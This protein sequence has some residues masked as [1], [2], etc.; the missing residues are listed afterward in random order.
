MFHIE[1]QLDSLSR[2]CHACLIRFHFLSV[3]IGEFQ[4][5]VISTQEFFHEIT[6]FISR[7]SSFNKFFPYIMN[8]AGNLL[9]QLRKRK[10]TENLG[11]DSVRWWESLCKDSCFS[12][13]WRETLFWKFASRSNNNKGVTTKIVNIIWKWDFWEQTPTITSFCALT[14]LDLTFS[15]VLL[16]LFTFLFLLEKVRSDIVK[17]QSLK[18]VRVCFQKSNLKVCVKIASFP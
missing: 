16:H 10:W 6:S 11:T 2:I 1:F 15:C 12:E 13:N 17:S 18:I 14:I 8:L 9:K 4:N 3:F 7:L 5:A